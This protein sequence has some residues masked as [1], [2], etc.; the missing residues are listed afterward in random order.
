MSILQNNNMAEILAEGVEKVRSYKRS[1][2]TVTDWFFVQE[3]K[4]KHHQAML[5]AG[6]NP[7]DAEGQAELLV[8]II[9]DMPLNII[10]GSAVPGSQDAG[11]SPSYALIN[12][13]FKVEKFAGYCDPVAIY[14]DIEPDNASGLTRERIEEVRAYWKDTEYVRRLKDVYEKTG[15]LTGEVVFFV[16]PVTGHTIPDFRDYLKYGVANRIEAARSLGTPY[17]NAMATALEAVVILGERFRQLA[18]A[19]A[20]GTEDESEK[21]R[22]TAM[23]DVLS[24][25]PWAPAGDLYDA[26]IMYTLLWQ[27]MVIEQAPNPYA[28][29][30]GN[31]DRILSPYYQQ[32]TMSR[33]CAVELV[34]NLLCF[35]QVGKRCWAISQNV[36]VGGKDEGGNDMTDEMTYIVLDAFY[37]TNDPQPALSMKVHAKTPDDLYDSAARFF[38]TPGHS[39]PSIFNDDS[40]FPLLAAQGINS[41]DLPDYSIAGCQEFLIM[42]KASLNTTNSWL[43]LAK[44][45]ELACNDGKSL[46]S[47]EQLGPT[48]AELGYEGIDNAYEHIEELFFKMLE[49]ILPAMEQAANSCTDLLGEYKPVP[50]TSAVMDSLNSGRD[51]RN[52]ENP[53]VRYHA[54]GCLIHGVSVVNDSFQA[55]QNA[56]STGKWTA[57][58]I[59][60]ALQKD[61]SGFD[62]LRS[63][64]LNQPRYGNGNDIIDKRAALFTGKISDMV[65]KLK[66][67]AGNKF[68]A[69]FSTP[70]THLLYGFWVG[71][72]PDGRN[73]RQMLG[74][75][76]DPLSDSVCASLPERI[77]S[78]WKMPYHKMTGGYASHIGIDPATL[79]DK[80]TLKQKSYWMRDSVIKPLMR[81]G[82][83]HE[84]APYYVYFNID[85]VEH[86]RKVLDN[87]EKYAPTGIY[88]MR[89]HGT[90]V[91]FLDLSPA[92]QEDI[93][94]RIEV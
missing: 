37:K 9:K 5:S 18:L 56:L 66:N 35:L 83:G 42:G 26:V 52:P 67:T 64:L 76:I 55:I 50:F 17:G 47:G 28:F 46:I 69:D 65:S 54:S 61:F 38:F 59:R 12:P 92:I 43:N 11:F 80:K 40:V 30:V 79:R 51:M 72:T 16:E 36:L 90:F 75:G 74:Y 1:Q 63:F 32:S 34:R 93:M 14:D 3:I 41:D 44:V 60:N 15:S 6:I 4:M 57:V 8:R 24:R 25:I 7:D 48:W 94:K 13:S 77:I 27:V 91:N 20:A 31:I 78:Y 49:N 2:E 87:P 45:L 82:E 10:P 89:I 58:D 21:A 84:E 81:L 29:S 53:G 19:L 88:I 68:L 71:A 22:L 62:E 23:A 70:S 39:T 73:A 86:L 33:E 85:S